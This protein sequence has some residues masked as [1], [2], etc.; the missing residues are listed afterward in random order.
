MVRLSEPQRA[1]LNAANRPQGLRHIPG[2]PWPHH[3]N[4]ERALLNK[5]LIEQ[6]L[7]RDGNGNWIETWHITPAGQAALTP[8]LHLIQQPKFL[9]RPGRNTGDYTTRRHRSIDELE[10]VDAPPSAIRAARKRHQDAQ[11]GDGTISERLER[12][13]QLAARN[14]VNL[15]YLEKALEQ[16]LRAIERAARKTTAA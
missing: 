15:T 12:A 1:M 7:D 16:R 6:H 2:R 11:A 10:A 14:G 3:P 9:S 13:R 8:E 4:T 5:G